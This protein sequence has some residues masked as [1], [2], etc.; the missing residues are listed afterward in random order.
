MEQIPRIEGGFQILKQNPKP[1]EFKVN[2]LND[3]YQ[4][5]RWSN[6]HLCI[7]S[8]YSGFNEKQLDLLYKSL[9]SIYP[10]MVEKKQ[11]IMSIS[12]ITRSTLVMPV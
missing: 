1:L 11:V 7:Y 9:D 8:T 10:N 4:Q 3:N 5:L 12:G 6:G 2:N